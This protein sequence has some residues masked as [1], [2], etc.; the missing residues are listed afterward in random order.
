M[1]VLIEI[2]H[3]RLRQLPDVVEAHGATRAFASAIE[4]G[5]KQADQKRDDANHNQ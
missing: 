2:E 4:R 5:K 1:P 3:R